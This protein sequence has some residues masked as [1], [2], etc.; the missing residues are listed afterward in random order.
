MEILKNKGGKTFKLS[1]TDILSGAFLLVAVVTVIYYM[2]GPSEGYLHSDCVDTMTWAGATIDSGKLFST[3]FYYPYLLPFGATFFV[4]PFMLVFGFTMLAFRLAM[5]TF[6]IVLS[7]AI[8]FT[9]R[10]MQWNRKTALTAVAVEL[11]T[12][13]SSNKLRELFWEHIIHYSLGALLAFV[14]LALTFALIK[15]YIDSNYNLFADK[16]AVVLSILVFIWSFFNA[17]DG[18]TTLALSS[19]PII[20]SIFIVVLLDNKN[21]IISKENSDMYLT[22]LIIAIATVLG[23]VVFSKI[24]SGIETSYGD[25]YSVISDSSEWSNNILKFLSQWTSL[26]GATYKS[27]ES[28]TSGENIMAAI[29]MAGSL[30]IFLVPVFALFLYGKLNKY[31]RIFLIF[32]WLMT[33]FILYGYVFGNLSSVNWRLSPIICSAVVVNVMVWKCL[34]TEF[35][36]QRAAVLFSSLVILSS[37]V[38]VGQIAKMPADYGRD[39]D[40]HK[41]IE[42]LE[43]NNLTYG[44]ATYWNANILTL[45]SSS[46]VKVRDVNLDQDQPRNGWLNCDRLWYEDQPG[47]DKY[48]FLL[49]VSE[50][51][52]LVSRNHVILENTSDIISEGNWVVLVKDSNIF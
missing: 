44:Y 26:L 3:S 52:D 15:K 14:L 29:K 8:Y 40:H 34:W 24:S 17:F 18:L 37:A 6:M 39:N 27:G 7:L 21:K 41:A 47:Q 50:Y 10:G 46:E 16:K 30:V 22:F 25:A 45:L 35:N 4:Y 38:T 48:F 43:K 33:G 13:S 28:I 49:T 23:T 11:I 42:L 9:A 5:L 51:N 19:I 36:L 32:H 20:G 31:E 12:V 2:F 1:A